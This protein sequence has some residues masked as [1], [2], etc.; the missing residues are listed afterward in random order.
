MIDCAPATCERLAHS[1][2]Q[3]VEAAMPVAVGV[4]IVVGAGLAMLSM[5]GGGW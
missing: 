2:P 1:A 4:V 3:V 5:G